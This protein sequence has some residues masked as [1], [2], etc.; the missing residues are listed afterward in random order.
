VC[1]H[2]RTCAFYGA[3][4][5]GHSLL[6]VERKLAADIGDT[7]DAHAAAEIALHREQREHAVL[8]RRYSELLAECEALKESRATKPF[9]L[10]LSLVDL[11][12]GIETRRTHAMP[13]SF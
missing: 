8:R 1:A 10:G 7:V 4:A 12:D 5:H 9:R 3:P 6:Q 2:E 11:S 13:H